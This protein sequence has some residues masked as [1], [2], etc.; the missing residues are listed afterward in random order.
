[1]RLNRSQLIIAALAGTIS[2]TACSRNTVETAGGDVALSDATSVVIDNQGLADMT[3]YVLEGGTIRRRLGIA[4]AARKTR[5][6]IPSAL[7]GNGRDLQ[8]LADPI[9]GRGNSVSRRIF[10]VPGDQVSLTLLP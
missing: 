3:I 10:V 4:G 7:V 8:F 1:M 2:A 5:L 9:A 6:S